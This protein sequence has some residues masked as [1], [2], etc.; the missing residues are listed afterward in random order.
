MNKYDEILKLCVTADDLRPALNVPCRRGGKVIATDGKILVAMDERLPEGDYA[1]NEFCENCGEWRNAETKIVFGS[2]KICGHARI[3]KFPESGGRLIDDA[4]A[5]GNLNGAGGF[6]DLAAVEA[7]LA[8]YEK[9]P[10]RERKPCIGDNCKDGKVYCRCCHHENDCGFCGGVGY[11]LTK[12][13]IGESYEPNAEIKIRNDF[14][15]AYYVSIVGKIMQLTG[16]NAEVIAQVENGGTVFRI[17]AVDCLLM[18][19]KHRDGNSEDFPVIELR[20]Q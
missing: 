13:I 11:T 10:I 1:D 15:Q 4:L 7:A 6:F 18:P 3:V 20:K 5:I 14:S 8:K 2:N 12:K 17:G 9:S 19:L 16:C